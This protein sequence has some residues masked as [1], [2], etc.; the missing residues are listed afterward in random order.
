M[1]KLYFLGGEN[2]AKQD[3]KE[4]NERAFQDAGG[5]PAVVVFSWARASFDKDYACRERL[6]AYFR[7]LGASAVDFAEYS[8]TPEEIARK[9][10]RSDLIY[11]TGGL[12]SVLVERLRNKDVD[13]LLRGYSGVI[14]GRSAGA[15]ALC[16]RCVITDRNKRAA[17]I[18]AG[19]GQVDFCVKV[20][21]KHSKDAVLRRLSKEERIYAV[22]ERAALVYDNGTLSVMGVLYVFENGEKQALNEQ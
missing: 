9:V 12:T 10:E 1:A 5:A 15:L 21:Y 18:V 20:H 17:K 19:L 2:V 8:D 14:V 11:I 13:G 7:S 4:I 16:K 6:F 3:A 22:P